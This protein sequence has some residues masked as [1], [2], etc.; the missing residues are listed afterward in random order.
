M[1]DTAEVDLNTVADAVVC[2]LGDLDALERRLSLGLYRLLAE[3][4]PVRR[5]ELA[6]HLDVPID[7][8][9][10]M[11]DGWPMLLSDTQGRVVGYE[12]LSLQE[13]YASPHRITIGGRALSAWCAWDTLF[14][15]ER[16]DSTVE[17]VSASPAGE[18][19]ISLTVTPEQIERADPTN[20]WMSFLMPG[21]E[22]FDKNVIP[23]LCHFVHFFPTRHAGV[24]WT[25][26]HPG[27]F[28]LTIADAH[29]LARR[30][31]TARYGDALRQES[32][33]Y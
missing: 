32:S 9:R 26:E 27:T 22:G 28:L 1:D 19:P 7:A 6:R 20:L 25:A 15:P 16:L 23:K 17:V 30:V 24:T 12:G 18:R 3:G 11:L 2:A 14:L 4:A 31:N 29:A 10:S 21:V 8:V 33:N 13:A 5:E